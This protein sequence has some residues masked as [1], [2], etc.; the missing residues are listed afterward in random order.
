M[1]TRPLS[2]E[3]EDAELITV[4][5]YEDAWGKPGYVLVLRRDDAPTRTA[6]LTE[7]EA[8]DLAAML[9]QLVG[10]PR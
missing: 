9:L 7:Q 6:V 10:F 1:A 4:D 5:G 3:T 2:I 8:R